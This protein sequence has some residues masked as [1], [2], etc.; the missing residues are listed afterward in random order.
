MQ[1][2]HREGMLALAGKLKGHQQGKC[3]RQR[4]SALGS[5]KS[6]EEGLV[7]GN[8]LPGYCTRVLF[9]HRR[10]VRAE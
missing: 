7:V 6:G 9:V 4:E 2:G 10:A 5:G 3:H 1:G 8:Q